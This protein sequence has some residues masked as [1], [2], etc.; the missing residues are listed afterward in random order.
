[1]DY[2][3]EVGG[4]LFHGRNERCATFRS[5]CIGFDNMS[6]AACGRHIPGGARGCLVVTVVV[7]EHVT[8]IWREGL[9]DGQANSFGSTGD[10]NGH[11]SLL[12]EPPMLTGIAPLDYFECRRRDRFIED[13]LISTTGA[14]AIRIRRLT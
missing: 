12:T 3:V 10:Q 14:V 9:S 13:D 11:S 4:R 5:T 2:L 7:E 8:R 6:A 1:M